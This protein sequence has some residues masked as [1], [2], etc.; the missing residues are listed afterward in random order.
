MS[1]TN[2]QLLRNIHIAVFS[3]SFRLLLMTLL[4]WGANFNISKIMLARYT[5]LLMIYFDIQISSTSRGP[6][7]RNP[8][9]QNDLSQHGRKVALKHRLVWKPSKA[10]FQMCS[11]SLELERYK[12]RK[13]RHSYSRVLINNC[14]C[15]K[16]S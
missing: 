8:R 7:P 2:Y 12:E 15:Q 10:I 1:L 9:I 11:R 6:I 14:L 16:I 5:C 13:P 3:F 4:L